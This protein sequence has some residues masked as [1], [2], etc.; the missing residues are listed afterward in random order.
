M[1]ENKAR[2]ADVGILVRMESICCR[3]VRD[4]DDPDC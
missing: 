1:A 3:K 4:W 2:V